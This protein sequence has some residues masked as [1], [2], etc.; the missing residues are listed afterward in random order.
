MT[1]KLPDLPY[2]YD[3]LAPFMSAETLQ[4]HHDKHHLAYV[5]NGN[6]LLAGSKYENQSIEDICKNAYADKNAGIVN[7]VGQ[8]FNHLHFWQWMKKGGGGKKLP[9]KLQAMVDKDL[10]GYDKM[11][12]DFVQA[13]VTQFGSGW[14]WLV[15]EGKDKLSIMAT[16]DAD[17]PLAHGKHA[18]L[19]LDVWE[20]AY[21]LDYQHRRLDY[22]AAFLGH[23]INWDFANQNLARHLAAPASA[24]AERPLPA[25]SRAGEGRAL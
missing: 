1:L 12:T 9:A 23:L 19:C 10:G 20:H 2:A 22:I 14:A 6:K 24:S 13:G 8:H 3:A 16:A 17:L 7:N 4:F 25:R 21:Y 11:R 5:E 18:L 15:A